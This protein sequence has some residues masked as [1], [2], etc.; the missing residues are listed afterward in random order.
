MCAYKTSWFSWFLHP[1]LGD[2][3]GRPAGQGAAPPPLGTTECCDAVSGTV[4]KEKEKGEEGKG[5]KKKEASL[6]SG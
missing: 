5:K 1:F 3:S 2:I 6:H 4:R